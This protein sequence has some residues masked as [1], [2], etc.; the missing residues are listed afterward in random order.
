[1]KVDKRLQGL[2]PNERHVSRND[3]QVPAPLHQRLTGHHHGVPR[4][5][6]ILLFDEFNVLDGLSN[7]RSLVTD[8][9]AHF[10]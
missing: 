2:C 9:H 8:D 6:L 4:T 3:E 10:F 7:R 5:E 1:M